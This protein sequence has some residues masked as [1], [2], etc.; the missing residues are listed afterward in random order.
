MR[1][2]LILLT[3][4][5]PYAQGETFVANEIPYLKAAFDEVVIIS[6]AHDSDGELQQGV[7]EG[8]ACM[9]MPDQLSSADRLQA[10]L[11][12][13]DGEPREEL[14]RVRTVY[15]L[16]VTRQVRN[17]IL[18]SWFKAKKFSRIVRRLADERSGARIYAYSYWANDMALAV[19]VARARGWVDVA[20]CRAHRWDVYFEPT[21]A[22]FLPFRQYLAENLDH[23]RFVSKD[24][25]SYF[26]TREGRDHPSLGHSS[27]GTERAAMEPVANR[28]PFVLI[29][30]SVMTPRKRVERIAEA[31]EGVRRPVTWIHIG[32]G[33]ARSSLERIA[34]RLPQSIRVELA[35]PLPNGEVLNTYRMRRPS[36]FVSLSESEGMPVSIMEAMSAGVPVIATAVGGVPEMVLHRQNGLLLERDPDVADVR[37]AIEEF[38]DMPEEEYRAYAQAAWSTWNVQFNAE[39]NYPRFIT[40]VF[41]P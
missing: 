10:A 17:T 8:V 25:L 5:Y 28:N 19:A 22:G 34:S 1:R 20:V 27:L 14:R 12:L 23:Y 9:R 4:Q 35:G 30:C 33:P 32:D 7:P 3:T 39:V 40:D 11:A 36:L 37:A 18:V 2:I 38:A 26:R 29:S 15:S 24:G 31:L 21:M 16:P 41:G 6:N 13:L